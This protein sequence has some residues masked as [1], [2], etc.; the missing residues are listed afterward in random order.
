MLM[1]HQAQARARARV[2]AQAEQQGSPLQQQ[3][4]VPPPQSI[5]TPQGI[6]THGPGLPVSHGPGLPVHHGP[7]L[8]VAP[9]PGVPIIAAAVAPDGKPRFLNPTSLNE[10]V[11]TILE[12]IAA[13]STP[14]TPAEIASPTPTTNPAGQYRI[15]SKQCHRDLQP[16]SAFRCSSEPYGPLETFKHCT[17]CIRKYRRHHMDLATF[18][19]RYILNPNPQRHAQWLAEEAERRRNANTRTD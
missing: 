13:L 9:E 8:P 17:E 11:L 18:R 1:W 10:P 7:G 4:V 15:C 3:A 5:S 12:Q 2:Q 16:P 19:E 14:T 6:S